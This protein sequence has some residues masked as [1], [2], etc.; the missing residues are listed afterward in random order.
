MPIQHRSSGFFGKTKKNYFGDSSDGSVTI[1][2]DTQLPSTLD[3]DMVVKNYVDL[4][5]DPGATLT[6]S[7]RCRGLLVY[8]S[9]DLVINGS[10]SMTA[11]GCKANPT[12]TSVTTDTP[13]PPSDGNPVDVSGI[14]I[15][16]F[17]P[18][19][20]DTGSSDFSGCGNAAVTAESNQLPVGGNGIIID[21][22]RVGGAGGIGEDGHGGTALNSPGGGGSGGGSSGYHGQGSAATCFSGGAAAGGEGTDLPTIIA[23]NGSPYGGAGGKGRDNGDGSGGGAGNPGGIGGIS[24]TG[25]A[26]ALSGQS[27][28]GGLLIIVVRGNITGSGTISSIGSNGG[29]T[30][31]PRINA[32][33]EG[34]GSGGGVVVLLFG[35]VNLFLGTV[36]TSGGSRGVNNS[37]F[38]G[39]EL[40]G[41]GGDGAQIIQQI[42]D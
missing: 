37:T 34:G 14:R 31:S 35:G 39:I 41:N 11:R 20:T 22:P 5:I 12:D 9:G 7:N 15:A 21:I 27:G 28:T 2:V 30:A 29:N 23:Q 8:V 26:P 13:V 36:D 19:Q 32:M 40:G 38:A 42:E 17:A 24:G 6:T 4:T 1:S 16:K 25:D 18:G 10:I 3:G 33:G